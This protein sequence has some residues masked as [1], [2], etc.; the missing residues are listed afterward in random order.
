MFKLSYSKTFQKDFILLS[1]YPALVETLK[2]LIKPLHKNPYKGAEK[3]YPRNLN[4][5]SKRINVQHRLV[6]V[7]D[8]DQKTVK[9]LSCWTHYE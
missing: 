3:L 1:S 9:L 2:D 7:V 4:R 5:Y 8:K 6:Y